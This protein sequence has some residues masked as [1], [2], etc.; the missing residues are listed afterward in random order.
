MKQ[1]SALTHERGHASPQIVTSDILIQAYPGC[2]ESN[3]SIEESLSP[4][5]LVDLAIHAFL[6]LGDNEKHNF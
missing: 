2:L 4:T 1:A 6:L 5:L 3:S